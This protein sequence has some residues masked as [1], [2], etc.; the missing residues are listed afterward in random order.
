MNHKLSSEHLMRLFTNAQG[1]ILWKMIKRIKK[2]EYVVL[3]DSGAKY[4]KQSLKDWVSD[5]K[6]PFA[7]GA[8]HF[9]SPSCFAEHV[10]KLLR[11]GTIVRFEGKTCKMASYGIKEKELLDKLAYAFPYLDLHG[12]ESFA[13]CEIDEAE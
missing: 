5:I 2:N 11:N 10:R 4:I 9:I 12:K 13:E 6:I 3:D 7:N 1:V 8:S